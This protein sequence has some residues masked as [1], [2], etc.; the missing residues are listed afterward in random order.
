MDTLTE[1]EAAFAAL[2]GEFH[3]R[4][5]AAEKAA[6]TWQWASW[7][8]FDIKP[9]HF[10]RSGSKPGRPLRQ[11]PSDR[12]NCVACGLD[13]EGR[14]VVERQFNEFGFYE[15]FYDWG[16]STV[17]AAHYDYYEERSRL[18]LSTKK[19]PINLVRA[20]LHD[21]RIVASDMAAIHGYTRETY[22]WEGDLVREVGV[23]NATR[24]DGVLAPLQPWHTARAHYDGAGV[25][26]RV[27]R[28][29]PASA[30]GRSEDLVEIMFERRGKTIYWNSP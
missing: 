29:W 23:Q 7:C 6:S 22:R 17:D 30:V 3:A 21:G 10:E 27:D 18:G 20:Q 12:R 16:I 25:L 28:V 2:G 11:E 14:V 26:H 8:W 9:L 4:K 13:R 5:K 24:K 15:T 1:V 19:Q